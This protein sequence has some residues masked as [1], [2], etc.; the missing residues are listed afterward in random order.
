MNDFQNGKQMNNYKI[1]EKL[2]NSIIEYLA[3]KPY[4]ESFQIIPELQKLE[5]IKPE[6]KKKK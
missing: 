3:H 6:N 4:Q 2:V 5:K 1:S